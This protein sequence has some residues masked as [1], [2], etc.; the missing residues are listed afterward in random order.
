MC[1]MGNL[2]KSNYQQINHYTLQPLVCSLTFILVQRNLLQNSF[3]ND[4][5]SE[6]RGMTVEVR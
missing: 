5:L 2:R 1:S 4:F 6:N 3:L